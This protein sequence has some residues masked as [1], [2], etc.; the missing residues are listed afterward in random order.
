MTDKVLE[1]A[2]SFTD[3]HFGCKSNS[4]VHNQDCL[5]FITWFCEQVRNDPSIDHVVFMGDWFENR[6][7][8]NIST[9]NYSYRGA[10]M[11]NELNLPIFFIIGNHDLYHKHTR[12]V[13]SV[14]NF[15]EFS[16]FVVIEE[17]VVIPNIGAGAVL[18]PY[19]FHNEY[20]TLGRFLDYKTWWGHFEFKGFVITGYSVT[21]Q[22]GPDP[23]HF[24]GPAHIFSG[25]FH[26]RQT[27]KNI[28][29]IGN[30]F[31][32]SFGDVGDSNRGMAIYDHSSDKITFLDWP[33][34][35]LYVKAS[36]SEI[37]DDKFVLSE[38]MFVKCIVDV[39]I[40]P[41]EGYNIKDTL[42]NQHGLREFALEEIS[43]M[44]DVIANT[45]ADLSD[46]D[47]DTNTINELV[48]KMLGG[49]KADDIDPAILIEQY[50]AL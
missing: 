5:N 49:V 39:P 19:L 26:K 3:I 22:D 8:I 11:L 42:S 7:A 48:I 16:N 50:K 20:P 32:T 34:A 44:D 10:R 27:S 45:V 4:D 25:H 18:S 43:E 40:S 2:A 1:K 35:P 37:L 33:G 14:V 29:Y 36:L 13:H 46:H 6:S 9:I 21:M 12:E 15:H 31:P 41:D 17:P 23:T 38:N 24:D 30:P 47:I 28:T